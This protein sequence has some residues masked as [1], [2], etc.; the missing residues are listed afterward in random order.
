MNSKSHW[1]HHLTTYQKHLGFFFE[2]IEKSVEFTV[3][4]EYHIYVILTL[5]LIIYCNHLLHWYVFYYMSYQYRS[6]SAGTS[7]LSD[8]DL[9]CSLLDQ[10]LPN[11]TKREQCRSWW[12]GW[13]GWS[14]STPVVHVIKHFHWVNKLFNFPVKNF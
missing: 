13:S 3:E 11:K 14:R 9:H 1:K 8:L 2:V 6:R 7:L 5:P 12:H 4:K 10:K